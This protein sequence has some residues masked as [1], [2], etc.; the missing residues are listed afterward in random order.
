MPHTHHHAEHIDRRPRGEID[1]NY[2]LGDA[3]IRTGV[4]AGAVIAIIA[5]LTPFSVGQAL[6]ER[7]YGYLTVMTLFGAAGLG[8][9]VFGLHLRHAAT[10]WDKD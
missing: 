9:L 1:R 6:A 8:L 7:M 2:F 4:A 3:L 10:H 5:V